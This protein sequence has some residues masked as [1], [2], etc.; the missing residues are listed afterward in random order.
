MHIPG[1]GGGRED[2]V[3]DGT[4]NAVEAALG[5][6]VDNVSKVLDHLGRGVACTPDW[7]AHVLNDVVVAMPLAAVHGRLGHGS[8]FSHFF[9]VSVSMYV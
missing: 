3:D 6:G 8:G 7:G 9:L 2:G 4:A 1:E 5:G